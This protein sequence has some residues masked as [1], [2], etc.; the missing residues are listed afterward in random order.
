M[1]GLTSE[2]AYNQNRKNASKHVMSVEVLNFFSGF[3]TQLHK[4]HSLRRTFLHFQ[5]MAVLIK[6]R[7][8]LLVLN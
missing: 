5:V 2:E 6:I 4:L 7:L 8:H 1:E 3:F